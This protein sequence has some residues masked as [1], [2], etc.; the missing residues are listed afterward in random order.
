MKTIDMTSNYG[1]F[2]YRFTAEVGEELTPATVELCRQ[3][4]ANI[5]YRVAGSAVDKALGIKERKS[6]E[7]SD[8]TGEQINAAVSK[9]IAELEGKDAMLK[10]LKMSFA[11][12]GQHVFGEGGDKPTIAATEMWTK[13]QALPAEKFEV[14]LKTLGLDENYTDEQGVLACKARLTAAMQAAKVAAA[15]AL[16]M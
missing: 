14:A 1:N 6:V 8:A 12:T 3:G 9:K 16:G 7:Y 10:G 5:A 2:A 11:V 4:L 13:V 15:T